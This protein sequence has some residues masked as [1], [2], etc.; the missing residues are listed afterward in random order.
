M[1][2]TPA[3]D[4]VSFV[5]RHGEEVSL[6]SNG[7][8]VLLRIIGGALLLLAGLAAFGPGPMMGPGG[9]MADGWGWW[10]SQG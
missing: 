6:M 3:P 9:M 10:G 2:R 4:R 7:V 8:R 1:A 5:D